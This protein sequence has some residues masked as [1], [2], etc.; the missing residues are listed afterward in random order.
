MKHTFWLVLPCFFRVFRQPEVD[1]KGLHGA[2]PFSEAPF[3][4]KLLSPR[5]HTAG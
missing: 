5:I 1:E 2:T 3:A 4:P